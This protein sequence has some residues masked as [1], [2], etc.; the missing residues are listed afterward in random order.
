MAV[1]VWFIAGCESNPYQQ[2][3]RLSLKPRSR[4]VTHAEFLAVR[5]IAP[6]PVR[7][8]MDLA[9]LT[10]QRQVDLLDLTWMNVEEEHV[11]LTPS[12]TAKKEPKIIG[13]MLTPALKDVLLRCRQYKPFTGLRLYLN[14]A[15]LSD[16]FTHEGFRAAWQRVIDEALKL[17]A[18]P[19]PDRR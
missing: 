19:G 13:V 2:V 3:K 6:E 15:R 4:Y 1:G 5:A 9:L 17:G 10:G 14:R 18:M 16:A 8:M 11:R 12:K 7:L